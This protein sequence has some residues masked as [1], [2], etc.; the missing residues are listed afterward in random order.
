VADRGG[1]IAERLGLAPTEL[2]VVLGH[3][4]EAVLVSTP[5]GTIVYAN[6]AAAKLLQL[7]SAADV[8][9]QK[10]GSLRSRFEIFA[11]DG[12]PLDPGRL[13]GARTRAGEDG[14]ELVVRFRPPGGGPDQLS[15]VRAVPILDAAGRLKFVVSFFHT[16]TDERLFLEAQVARSEAEAAAATLKKLEAV[17]DVALSHLELQDLLPALLE[18]IVQLFSA[19]TC[20]ILLLDPSDRLVLRAAV[21]FAEEIA[22]AVPVPLGAGLAG[23]VAATREP[24]LV[25]NLDEL[26]LISPVLRER[27]IRSLAAAP[28]VA[29]GRTIG[30][31]HAG[32]EE[33][34]HF[35]SEDVRLLEV[36]G[37]RIALAVNHSA[38]REAEQLAQQRLSFLAEASSVLASSLNYEDTLASIAEL[39]VPKLADWCTIDMARDDGSIRR[40]AVAHVDPAKVRWAW[41][42]SRR[43]ATDPNESSGVAQVLRT[44]EPELVSQVTPELIAEAAERRPGLK[45]AIDALEL[46][47]VMTVPFVARG[48]TLGAITFVS[49]ESRRHYGAGDLEF[50]QE[51]ARRAA[52]AIDN[53][54]LYREAEERGRAA[55]I[56]ASVGDGVLLIDSDGIVRYWNRAAETITG[57]TAADVHDRRLNEVLPGWAA[58]AQRIPVSADPSSSLRA[59]SLPL[60]LPGGRE[61]WIS[62]SA[63][64]AS[65]GT[66]YGFRDL[67][68]ERTLETLKTEF[69]ST[70]SHEL[71]T[72]LAAIYGAAMTL[73]RDDVELDPEQRDSLLQVVSSEA[74]RL[75]RTVNAILWAGR[76]ETDALMTAIGRCDPI[77]LVTD[78]VAAQ[79]VHLPERIQLAFDAPAEL[80]S[81]A[82]DPDKLS[83]VLVNLLDNAIKYSPRGGRVLVTASPE[84]GRVRFDVTDEGIGI[85]QNEQRR[86]FEK[87]Y[88]LDPNMAHGV[89]G[90]GLGLYICRELLRRMNG[91]LWVVSHAGRGS[92]FSF[93]LPVSD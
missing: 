28:L 9:R 42:L 2:E 44:G 62:I 85:P 88:R 74:D 34:G 39:S 79:R 76:L 51:L 72:P 48:R 29:D 3:V 55:R 17:A 10:F 21:G 53:A 64:E 93:E 66:V 61:I 77:Q 90:T 35:T 7:P 89:G 43:H 75:A 82:A 31:V 30:V 86:I 5:E 60:A 13:P 19:D 24:M 33:L 80:P 6:E 41:E 25:P 27:G 46:H 8:V 69:V 12:S 73:R 81:V 83:Q 57:L 52:V 56:L 47:S 92:T 37:D 20:A 45:V 54:Q 14:G 38:L 1:G 40:L 49:A 67:T 32:S 71:R 15:E 87:F 36:M 16:V 70:V 18:K 50:V 4:A 23:R 91:R 22:D 84:E 11:L 78:V 68:E 59:H 63:V 65:E 26:E 58:V